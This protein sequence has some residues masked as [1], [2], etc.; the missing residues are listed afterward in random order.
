MEQENQ[1][2]HR[3]YQMLQTER[4]LLKA[5]NDQLKNTDKYNQRIYGGIL[6][7]IGVVLSFIL[8]LLGKR[9]RRSE[10]N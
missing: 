2:M 5:D 4:D 8:Q 6:I 10:W 3:Q 9:K 7:V 1:N